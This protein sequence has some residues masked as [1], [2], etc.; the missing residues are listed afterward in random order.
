MQQKQ[1]K[2]LAAA[3]SGLL[4]TAI[5]LTTQTAIP[6]TVKGLVTGLPIGMLILAL[7]GRRSQ[8]LSA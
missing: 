2:I 3:G 7:I 4:A 8:K 1:I 6:D 5:V